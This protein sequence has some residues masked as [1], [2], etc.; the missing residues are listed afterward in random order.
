MTDDDLLTVPEVCRILGEPQKPLSRR[1]FYRW[2][3]IGKAPRCVRLP[4]NEIR[5]F[6]HDLKMWLERHREV[7]A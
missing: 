2:R 5:V 7:A 3:E 6:R 4:N 1:T